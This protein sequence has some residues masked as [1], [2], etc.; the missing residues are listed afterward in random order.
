MHS[1]SNGTR[2]SCSQ[3][4]PWPMKT[5][6]LICLEPRKPVQRIPSPE[7]RQNAG[8]SEHL[9]SRDG[10][11]CWDLGFRCRRRTTERGVHRCTDR[12]CW[13]G[14]CMHMHSLLSAERERVWSGQA[15]RRLHTRADS[16]V[17]SSTRQ[18]LASRGDVHFS[19]V[20]RGQPAS[21]LMNNILQR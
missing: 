13:R 11:Q 7:N 1:W 18:Y 19:P 2:S 10:T 15:D 20:R 6:W 21:K 9:P 3:T 16:S 14:R 5:S 17:T 12:T 4:R 8:D